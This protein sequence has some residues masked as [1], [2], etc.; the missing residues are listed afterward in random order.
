[1]SDWLDETFYLPAQTEIDRAVNYP[2]DAP[3][4]AFI[5]DNGRL[6][7][8]DD[9]AILND[10][11]AVLSVGSNRAP[12]QLRRKFGDAAIIPVT[13]AV[14]HDCD[15]VHAAQLG[16]YGAVPCTAFPAAG[17]EVRL[18]VAWLDGA[19]LEIMHRT[20]AVGIAYDYI[21]FNGGSVTHLPLPAA[22]GEI[23]SGYQPVFGYA[24]RGGVLDIGAGQ[25]AGLSRISAKNRIFQTMSQA[26]AAKFVRQLTGHDDHRSLEHFVADMQADRAERRLILERLSAHV[27]FAEEA[28]WQ[29]IEMQLDDLEAYL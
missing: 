28:P 22:G 4:T 25:P 23:I 26:E 20:E 2:Y 8:F 3:D 7:A 12:V 1:M 15:I 10:R 17:C 18:N 27:L 14:L 5:F 21:R 9:A 29:I 16:Y 13:P 19:Q 6:R 11:T 24:A